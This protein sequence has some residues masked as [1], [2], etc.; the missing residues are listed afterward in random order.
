[1]L[2]WY[3]FTTD[4]IDAFGSIPIR[5]NNSMNYPISTIER[6]HVIDANG[7]RL[8]PPRQVVD[9]LGDILRPRVRSERIDGQVLCRRG[10]ESLLSGDGSDPAP[11]LG[12]GQILEERGRRLG[13][14]ICYRST[15][16]PRPLRPLPRHEAE[17]HPDA[18][19]LL[20]EQSL[21]VISYALKRQRNEVILDICRTFSGSQIC[22]VGVRDGQLRAIYKVLRKSGI[23]S[24]FIAKEGTKLSDKVRDG[25]GV[26]V[27]TIGRVDS[28][29]CTKADLILCLDASEA[30]HVRFQQFLAYQPDMRPA[31][32]GLL[33][34]SKKLNSF[35]RV[36]IIS[37]FGLHQAHVVGKGLI[38]RPAS[39]L[40]LPH[41]AS[42]ATLT[43]TGKGQVIPNLVTDTQRNRH[44]AKVAAGL[45]EAT[46]PQECTTDRFREWL[47]DRDAA[48]LTTFVI[49]ATAK[50]ALQIA[51][52][53]PGWSLLTSID[54]DGP[55]VSRM[56]EPGR[57]RLQAGLRRW[58]RGDN[59][60]LIATVDA[61]SRL[62]AKKPDVI[63]WAGA[64]PN[65]PAL[66]KSWFRQRVD[67]T[68]PLLIVDFADRGKMVRPMTQQRMAH[69]DHAGIFDV[70]VSDWQGRYEQFERQQAGFARE[71]QR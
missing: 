39:R 68:Q 17:A 33:G 15:T 28:D 64:G 46:L 8:W 18:V 2:N 60:T 48:D 41:F 22:I 59:N 50:Q 24:V 55:M 1:M 38:R 62:G 23:T 44:V 9:Q 14:S 26:V 32:F 37:T 52:R 40:L 20:S 51:H 71:S 4:N 21:G 58:N 36:S 6:T 53:L 3:L 66:P 54:L 69:Y 49:A 30:A 11:M 25:S 27:S 34:E 16:T 7:Y 42:A 57:Q 19:R 65:M 45:R 70:G 13:V 5:C 47:R 29:F 35:E 61:T 63:V 31:L 56:D 43:E 10:N 67:R 12:L